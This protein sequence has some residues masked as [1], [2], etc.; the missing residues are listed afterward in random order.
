[1]LDCFEGMCG[2]LAMHG[3]TKQD[4]RAVAIRKLIEEVIKMKDKKKKDA[5]KREPI[6][7]ELLVEALSKQAEANYG[8][9]NYAKGSGTRVGCVPEHGFVGLAGLES[10]QRQKG[11]PD[12]FVIDEASAWGDKFVSAGTQR[13]PDHQNTRQ[14]TFYHRSWM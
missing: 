10:K 2:F 14:E 3:W 4:E 5:G 1:M 11:I 9:I 7:E 6:D 12:D 8:P 13:Y